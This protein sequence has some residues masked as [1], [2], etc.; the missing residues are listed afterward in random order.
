M[1]GLMVIEFD[2]EQLAA[3]AAQVRASAST[4]SAPVGAPAF[5][6]KAGP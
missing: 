1:H 5:A 6:A 4:T 2:R 3:A